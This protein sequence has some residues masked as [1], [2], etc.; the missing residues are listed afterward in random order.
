MLE[1]QLHLSAFPKPDRLR[2]LAQEMVL[3]TLEPVEPRATAGHDP[4]IARSVLDAAYQE[5]R[6]GPMLLAPELRLDRHLEAM[7]ETAT[8]TWG[9]Y[10][11]RAGERFQQILNQALAKMRSDL[12]A[13]RCE[14][15]E[16]DGLCGGILLTD[17]ERDAVEPIC[18]KSLY[19]LAKA[20]AQFTRQLYA[21]H[22][23][24]LTGRVQIDFYFMSEPKDAVRAA[25]KPAKSLRHV[26]RRRVNP[27]RAAVGNAAPIAVDPAVAAV[28]AMM[29][30]D[31][32]ANDPAF[33]TVAAMI[34]IDGTD[35]QMVLQLA[36]GLASAARI[37]PLA[38]QVEVQ[39]PSRKAMKKNLRRAR[40]AISMLTPVLDGSDM[41]SLQV[42]DAAGVGHLDVGTGLAFL[43]ALDQ[44]AE[45]AERRIGS[46]GGTGKAWAL[47][48]ALSAKDL[49]ALAV[50]EVWMLARKSL[51][52]PSSAK[53]HAVADAYWRASGG[54]KASSSWGTT[55]SGWRRHFQR[56][57]KEPQGSADR[58]KVR[59]LIA[60]NRA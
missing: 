13:H 28:A 11:E 17:R 38:R 15:C 57:V 16:S 14:D 8:E 1:I 58:I 50:A 30:A 12:P 36:D 51:P 2:F 26:P 27:G 20:G 43:Q 55:A 7:I 29:A 48:T 39:Q 37:L 9:K 59:T 21:K 22:L 6:H 18:L 41:P 23:P 31:A 19:E 46:N 42:L 34:A 32:R 52:A 44:R 60:R 33:V 45:K 3:K 4:S 47:P 54:A 25:V 49:C 24:V 53:L 56:A 10:R 40:M 5:A 35:V